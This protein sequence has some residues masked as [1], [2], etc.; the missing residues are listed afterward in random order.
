M[1]ELL[2]SLLV[3][4][5]S[6]AAS[7]GFWAYMQRKDSLKGATTQ[8]LLGLAHDR[9]IQLGM[10]YVERGWISK[11]EYS[12]LMRYLYEPYAKFGGNGLADK[13][14][15]DVRKLPFYNVQPPLDKDDYEA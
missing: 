1:V 7:S 12:D 2:Q 15:E 10:T 6:V 3:I 13:V 8:L 11:T 14:I 4:A 5:S 9:I